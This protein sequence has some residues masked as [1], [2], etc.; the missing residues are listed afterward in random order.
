HPVPKVIDFGLAKAVHQPLTEHSLHTAPGAMLGTLLYISPEQAALNNPDLDTRTDVY[1]LGVVLY[2]L[3]TGTTPLARERLHEAAWHERLRLIREEEPP[4]PSARLSGSD[5]LPSVAARRQLEPVRLIKLVRGELDWIVMKCLEKDRSRRYV[6]ANGL[7]RDVERYLS[8]ETGEASPPGAGHRLGK[9]VKRNKAQLAAAGL[10][11]VTLLSGMAGTLWGLVRAERALADTLVAERA[12]SERA[13]GERRA[14]EEAQ[15]RLAQVEKGTEVLASVFR[16]LDPKDEDKE[17][18]TLRVLLG[19]RL[20]EALQQLE[21]EAVG[22]P[23]TVARL[24]HVIG[25]SL[26]GLGHLEQAEA[27]FGRARRARERLLGA[28]HLRTISTDHNLAWLYWDQGRLRQAESLYRE[29]V[30]AR[31]AR[32]GADQ[33]DTLSSKNNLALVYMGRGKYP[34]AEALFKE[35]L[36]TRI[37]RLGADDLK[38]LQSK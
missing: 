25:I 3:L 19:R 22:D 35:V 20:G 29:V 4:R 23:L 10:V 38:T 8:D 9:F 15:R 28:E 13:A 36:A 2:E 11:L 30:A 32:L 14:R 18:V 6:T 1:A 37:A 31:T 33:P 27:A 7:A 17:G 16:D 12:A 24:Q 5:A 21:G 26:R 34:E